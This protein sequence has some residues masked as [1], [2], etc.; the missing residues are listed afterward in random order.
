[1]SKSYTKHIVVVGSARSGTS[2]LSEVLAQQ[3]RYRLLFEPEHAT[4]TKKGHLLCDTWLTNKKDSKNAYKYFTRVLKNRVDSDWIAQNSNRKYKRH[5]W[6]FVAKKYVIKFVRCNLSAHYMSTVL[7]VPILHIIRNP[8][9]VI[10]SQQRANF[11]WLYDLS[12]FVAQDKLVEL[13]EKHYSFNL[14]DYKQYSPIQ[15]LCI[16]WCIENELTLNVFGL[17]E[18][19]SRVLKYEDLIKD[20]KNFYDLCDYFD[21]KPVGQIESIYKKP[22]SKTHKKSV[23]RTKKTRI[24]KWTAEEFQQI[25]SI[26][27][28]FKSNLYLRQSI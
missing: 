1:M 3:H 23:I 8:Y 13:I 22:S 17:Y 25:N 14:N 15:I 16:R 24:S 21:L 6:P 19:K 4:R 5:L 18:N 20:I 12:R 26:L 7:K 9:D 10:Q 11:P 28:V 27:D 2:W